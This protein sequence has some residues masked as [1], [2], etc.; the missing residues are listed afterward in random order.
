[1]KRGGEE[2][3]R[4]TVEGVREKPLRGGGVPTP[5]SAATQDRLC[6]KNS[7]TEND[8]K[9]DGGRRRLGWGEEE[10]ARPS[11][12]PPIS[13]PFRRPPFLSRRYPSPWGI[14]G[15]SSFH[16]KIVVADQSLNDAAVFAYIF[17]LDAQR[18]FCLLFCQPYMHYGRITNGIIHAQTMSCEV[19]TYN[20]KQR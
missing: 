11:P 10:G 17:F 6:D 7:P 20:Y 12:S 4:E 2:G 13:A 8:D 3:R 18:V 9:T 5:A 15:F 19:S 14:S 16:H 1:M